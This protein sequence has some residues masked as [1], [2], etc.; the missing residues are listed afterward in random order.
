ME[1]NITEVAR[2]ART[3][4]RF[5][6]AMRQGTSRAFDPVRV[7]VLQA[8]VESGP[9]RAGDIAERV[10]ALPS[11]I[12]RHVQ[13]LA[14]SELVKTLP[15]PNDRRAV[16]IEATEAGRAELAQF[17]ETGDQVFA[18]VIADW[19]ER[20][21]VTLTELLDRMIENWSAV[22]ATQQQ[23][24]HKRGPGRFGWSRI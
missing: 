13:A 7:G 8:A 16:L 5:A 24:A 18:A 2:L 12:T 1:A 15:D 3:V 19:S 20:D 17:I 6:E 10:D 14:E 23:K 9:L 22:G 11:S 21:I 4:T